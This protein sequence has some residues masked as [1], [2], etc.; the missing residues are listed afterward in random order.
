MLRSLSWLART[1]RMQS[2]L[3]LPTQSSRPL[4]ETLRLEIAVRLC[5]P[6][7]MACVAAWEEIV[8]DPASGT[9]LIV[10]LGAFLWAYQACSSLR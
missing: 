8:R 7:P 2:L 9:Q 6:L 1:A 4:N 3:S 5:M 10:L